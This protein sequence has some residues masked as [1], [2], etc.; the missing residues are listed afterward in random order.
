ML[1]I[2]AS[3]PTPNTATIPNFLIFGICKRQ[4]SGKGKIRIEKSERT[5]TTPEIIHIK[6][7][8]IQCPGILGFHTFCIGVHW[9]IS[10][11]FREVSLENIC[12]LG[13]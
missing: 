5:L 3:R 11:L 10:A 1:V 9:Q 2:L 8:S 7:L 12:I 13:G 4:M 6:R